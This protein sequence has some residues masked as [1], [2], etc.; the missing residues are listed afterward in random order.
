MVTFGTDPFNYGLTIFNSEVSAKRAF[1]SEGS[2]TFNIA[3]HS[4]GSCSSGITGN[5]CGATLVKKGMSFDEFI[6]CKSGKTVS[7]TDKTSSAYTNFKEAYNSGYSAQF[8][9]SA[10]STSSV[11]CN[12]EKS[13]CKCGPPNIKNCD[14]EVTVMDFS[15]CECSEGSAKSSSNTCKEKACMDSSALNYA[16]PNYPSANPKGTDNWTDCNTNFQGRCYISDSSM[17]IYSDDD[18][19]EEIVETV[20]STVQA[21][22]SGISPV[23]IGAGVVGLIAVVALMK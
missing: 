22:S 10:P 19:Q 9:E 3:D 1:K 2:F 11:G 20:Q 16:N 4:G 8:G 23:M 12:P 6:K 21:P 14:P 18:N 17:C 5:L 15:K 13:G 7:S